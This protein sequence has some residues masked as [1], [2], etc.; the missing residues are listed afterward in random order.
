MNGISYEIQT[1]SHLEGGFLIAATICLDTSTTMDLETTIKGY[2]LT[3]DSI[4][5]IFEDVC[6]IPVEDKVTFSS[7]R[8]NDIRKPMII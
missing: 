5:V 6:K 2:E 8:T 3:H 1:E 4:W 7:N